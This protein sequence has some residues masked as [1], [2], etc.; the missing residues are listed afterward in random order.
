MGYRYDV[1]QR[2]LFFSSF[3]YIVAAG[4]RAVDR[5][6]TILIGGMILSFTWSVGG[7]PNHVSTANLFPVFP[8]RNA[9]LLG[10]F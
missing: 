9:F 8:R 4:A 3:L 6:S 1:Q 7:M 5:I 2:V 10:V